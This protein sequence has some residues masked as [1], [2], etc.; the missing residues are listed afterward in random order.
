MTLIS[1]CFDL[2]YQRSKCEWVLFKLF[3]F[4]I[5]SHQSLAE[6]VLRTCIS[7][8]EFCWFLYSLHVVCSTHIVQLLYCVHRLYIAITSQRKISGTK[9]NS[10]TKDE[11]A[12]FSMCKLYNMCTQVYLFGCILWMHV[13]I[14]IWCFNK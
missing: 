12:L 11:I 4:Y 2:I 13:A 1:I 10:T 5:T 9:L 8:F 7:V 6:H 3:K 14:I